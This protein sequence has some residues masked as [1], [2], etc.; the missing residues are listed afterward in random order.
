MWLPESKLGNNG[1]LRSWWYQELEG[2]QTRQDE[3]RVPHRESN[4]G[5]EV[6][7]EAAAEY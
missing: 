6:T 7:L 5:L 2:Q 4:E 1:D 3:R